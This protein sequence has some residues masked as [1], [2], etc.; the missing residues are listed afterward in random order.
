MLKFWSEVGSARLREVTADMATWARVALWSVIGWRIY[1][2]IAGYAEAA[3]VFASGGARLQGAGVDNH[4]AR[5]SLLGQS[6][7]IA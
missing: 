4:I 6:S 3:R 1:S 2:A 7:D 5:R